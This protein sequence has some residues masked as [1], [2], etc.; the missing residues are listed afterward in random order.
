VFE[1]KLSAARDRAYR[2]AKTVCEQKYEEEDGTMCRS[3]EAFCYA[4]AAHRM[5]KQFSPKVLQR[6]R[7]GAVP[8]QAAFGS[9]AL[10][11]ST[12]A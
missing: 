11:F 4:Q 3:F 9:A 12:I 1:G 2:R 10:A 7:R 5:A 8:A 6:Q